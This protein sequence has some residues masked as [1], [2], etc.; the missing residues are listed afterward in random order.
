MSEAIAIAAKGPRSA[1]DAKIY[2]MR[3]TIYL[4]NKEPGSIVSKDIDKALSDFSSAISLNPK[5]AQSY[6]YRG[7]AHNQRLRPEAAWADF[8]QAKTLDPSDSAIH[9]A[10]EK[11]RNFMKSTS[12]K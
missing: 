7:Y 11:Q 3:G 8:Q 2:Q 6:L 5:D 9:S 12:G 1:E 4:Q 10:W